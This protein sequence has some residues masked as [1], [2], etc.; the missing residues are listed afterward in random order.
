MSEDKPELPGGADTL[1]SLGPCDAHEG[2]EHVLATKDGLPVG[3]THMQ[4][5]NDGEPFPTGGSV[6]WTNKEGRV[7][8]SMRLGAGDGPAQVATPKYRD[9]WESIFGAKKP[10]GLN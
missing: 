5:A 1:R 2:Q 6:Y 3:V 10:S 4:R 8:D 9:N 7:V